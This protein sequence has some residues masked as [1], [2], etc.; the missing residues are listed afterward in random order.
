MPLGAHSTASDW[1]ITF[2]PALDMAEG[3]VNGPPCQIQ[4]VRME[5]TAP[6]FCS[7]IQ[8]LPTSWVT[9]KEPRKT[10]LEMASKPRGLRSSV[11]LMKL[12]AAL[13]IRPVSAPPSAQTV[14]TISWMASGTRMSQARGTTLPP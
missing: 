3:T 4:V 9:K 5:T 2:S 12:P 8:R 1:V 11:R 6:F 13:L 10:M 14:S 7:A